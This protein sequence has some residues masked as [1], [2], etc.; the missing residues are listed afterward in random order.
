MKPNILFVDDEPN[1]IEG[2]K[3]YLWKLKGK[4]IIYFAESGEEA[5]QIMK[6]FQID[7]VIADMRM[8]HMNGAELLE[9][10][11]RDYP[12][13]I[14]IILTGHSDQ[15]AILNTVNLA[16]QFFVKPCN[17]DQLLESIDRTLKI[18]EGVGRRKLEEIIPEM[19]AIKSMPDLSMQLMKELNNV[20]VSM[21]RLCEILSQ[22]IIMTAEILKI[23]N[24][25]FFGLPHRVNNVQHAINLLGVKIIK[26]L[27]T[28]TNIFA[29]FTE[30]NDI[31][32]YDRI[33]THCLE[34]AR[35]AKRIAA[36]AG[37]SKEFSETCFTAGLLH[38][39]GKLPVL[40]SSKYAD[41]IK[42]YIKQEDCGFFEAELKIMGVNH[43][44]IG[45][46]ILSMWGLP[47]EIVE[48][49]RYHHFPSEAEDQTISPL[50]FVHIANEIISCKN[51][52]GVETLPFI[53]M[54]YLNKFNLVGSLQ[55]FIDIY[56]SESQEMI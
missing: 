16:H 26:A 44:V 28:Y 39:I 55:S 45:A 31:A 50:T 2:Q 36:E 34:T 23:I 38:D 18:R 51:L 25:A 54:E 30:E 35:L 29:S 8:P 49:V 22:D 13:A 47:Q 11:K 5:L 43:T 40:R 12:Q 7:C 17:L 32:I 19:S 56:K 37:M 41:E 46:Y 15:E 6:N 27:A 4:W 10:V 14:R 9:I 24:S 20:D 33:R 1:I 3:R 42:K 48:T 21:K 52:A 53:D